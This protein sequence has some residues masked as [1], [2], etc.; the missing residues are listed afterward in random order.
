MAL[1]LLEGFETRNW[2]VV[3]AGVA[4]ES[5]TSPRTGT[6]CSSCSGGGTRGL[7]YTHSSNK[8]TWITG[9]AVRSTSLTIELYDGGSGG[10]GSGVSRWRP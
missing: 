4:G 9:I 8:Q 2:A 1:L 3:S 10:G 5:V 6:Y 7:A